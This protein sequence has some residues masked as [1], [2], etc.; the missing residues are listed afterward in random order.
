MATMLSQRL[1]AQMRALAHR[2]VHRL[3]DLALVV[4]HERLDVVA[5]ERGAIAA[6]A[7]L[8]FGICPY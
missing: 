2:R 7:S 4:A 8:N 5:V 1:E 3:H 6:A